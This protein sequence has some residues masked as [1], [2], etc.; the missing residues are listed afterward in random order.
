M[1]CVF[2][3][4]QCSMTKVHCAPAKAA[5]YLELPLKPCG[6]HVKKQVLLLKMPTVVYQ[7]SLPGVC[8]LKCRQL[9]TKNHCLVFAN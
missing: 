4:I 7:K 3:N 5:A 1:K 8:S 6:V 2:V 9:S